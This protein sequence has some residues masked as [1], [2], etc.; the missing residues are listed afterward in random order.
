[1]NKD[2][3]QQEL[4]EKIKEGIKPSDLKKQKKVKPKINEDEGY[5][6]DESNKSI[7]IPPITP[8]KK[9]KQ[10]EGDVNIGLLQLIII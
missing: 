7:P 6:S 4:K 3:L 8:A 10:L 1:M 9:I 5:E 2:K